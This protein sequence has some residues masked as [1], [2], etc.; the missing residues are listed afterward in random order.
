M[1]ALLELYKTDFRAWT[2]KAA[3]LLRQHQFDQLSIEELAKEL[4][5]LGDKEC[6]R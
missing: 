4:E 6:R 5:D 2:L 1:S 3:E